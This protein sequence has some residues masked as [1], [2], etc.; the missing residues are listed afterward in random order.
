MDQRE[1]R[2]A[3]SSRTDRGSTR[4]QHSGRK[5]RKKKIRGNIPEES[6]RSKKS[7]RARRRRRNMIIRILILILFILAAAGAFLIWQRYG[8]SDVKADLEQ[9]Y[10]LR[11]ENDL[12][13]VINNTVITADSDSQGTDTETPAPGK[14]F[15][16]QYYLEYSVVRT[17][18]NSRFYWD[19]N[20]NILLYTLPEGSVVVQA[21]SSEYTDVT[22]QKSED[23]IIM[24]TEG[25]TAYIALPFI[26]EYTNMD[27]SVYEDP[28]RVAI[29]SRWGE[30]QTAMVK[31]DTQVRY[32]GGV[33]SPILTNVK[34]S[35][36]VTVLEEE[37]NWTQVATEDGFVGYVRKSDLRD[38]RTEN[39]SRD[40]KEPVY[41]NISKDYRINMVW[42]NVSN[43][44]AN[45]YIQQSL[46]GT[47][48]L[49]TIAPT[50]FSI[51]DTEGNL[52]SI[53][54]ADYVSYA[55]QSGLEVWAVLRD[56]HGGINSYDETYQVLSYTSKRQRL[57]SQVIQAALASDVDGINLDFELVSSECG[58]H[59]IQFV[60]E[61]S[62]AC[63]ENGLVFSVDNYVPQPYNQHY[64]IAEQGVVADYVIIMA[65][66][67][68]TDASYEAG[69]V[70]SISYLQNGIADAL[71]SVPRERLIAGVPFFTR[72][73]LETPKTED[74]L[75]GEAGT[76]A[77]SYPD[78]IS[79]K[80]M[81]MDEAAQTVAD[82]GAQTVWDEE[83]KQN[84]AEW[85]TD[86]GT[87]KIWLE[88][89]DSLEEK[90]KVINEN[91]LAGIAEW[92]L[93]MENQAVW[94]LIRSYLN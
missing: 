35:D 43:A 10:G 66:D 38:A 5:T 89:A 88:D 92:S 33:K 8:P 51:S 21:D 12:A 17:Q 30:I 81:G 22:E 60:R 82:A 90:L 86:G 26:Q 57:I 62:V 65:Y 54:S 74:E 77:A 61:L 93:G 19:S 50:W 52:T 31:H 76:E 29:T 67:E 4:R 48:G 20:E 46:A 13:V 80:A 53:A 91:E 23:Y 69:S 44:T 24:K 87:Y 56:F 72:L 7:G 41:T 49:N 36:K 1:S 2:D 3:G 73:W 25:S 71:D 79:S 14:I 47:E 6:G 28:T 11:E 37:D 75:A 63:R 85:K 16:G 45:G 58:P 42:H 9:Y 59:Y 78:K 40:F 70:A 83:T 39:I 68:H 18:I 84:Y 32:R 15:D 64:D 27:Y 34:K 94:N 55:H